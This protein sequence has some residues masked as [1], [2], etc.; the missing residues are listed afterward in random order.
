MVAES[1]ST[2]PSSYYCYVFYS[3]ITQEELY[4]VQLNIICLLLPSL[5]YASSKEEHYWI[6]FS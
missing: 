3:F 1:N 5:P 4:V 6:V 2:V